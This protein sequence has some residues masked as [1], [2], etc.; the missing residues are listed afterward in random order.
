MVIHLATAVWLQD[1]RKPIN[2]NADILSAYLGRNPK[3][4]CDGRAPIP[5]NLV[6][7]PVRTELAR[8]IRALNS[9]ITLVEERVATGPEDTT[10]LPPPDVLDAFSSQREVVVNVSPRDVN[11]CPC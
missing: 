4:K 6:L 8:A 9:I 2:R 5:L 1:S 3:D 11:V 7:P 10:R